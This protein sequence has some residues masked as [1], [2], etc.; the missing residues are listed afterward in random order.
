MLHEATHQLASEASGFKVNRWLNEGLATYFST[1]RIDR[2][3]L[4]LG[5][6][7]DQTYPIWWLAGHTLS[8]DMQRDRASGK[9]IS[10]RQLLTGQGG[11]DVDTHFNDYYLCAWSLTHFLFH[12]DNG[13]YAEVYRML[14][15]R[16]GSRADFIALVGPLEQIEAHWYPY[17]IA[18]VRAARHQ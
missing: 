12:Y 16:G 17:L 15:A 11:P 4:R 1:S 9:S 3:G 14:I 18:Q 8:G 2:S 10:L 6:T 13:K 5:D 7:D